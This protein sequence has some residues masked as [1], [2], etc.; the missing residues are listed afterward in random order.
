MNKKYKLYSWIAVAVALTVF[1][2]A[3]IFMS[4]LSK[5]TNIKI[6]LTANKKYD[7]TDASYEFL[8]GY[9]KD[10]KL[11]IL[12]S[13]TDQD[14]NARAILD[15]YAAANSHIKIENVDVE[16]NPSFGKE[17]ANG[18]VL[19]SNSVIVASG[20]KSRVIEN[21]E[22]YPVENGNITGIDVESKITSALKF[23]SSEE[24][25]VVCF[26]VGHDEADFRGAREAL[27]AEN[28]DVR[29]I[30]TMTEDIPAET[31]VL[32]IPR[33]MTDFSTE[34]IA[35]LDSYV[36]S[37][38]AVQLYVSGECPELP[39]LNGWLNTSGIG[40]NENEI[41]ESQN[42]VISVSGSYVF[43]ANYVKNAVTEGII[44]K[45]MIS[46]YIPFAKSLK[47]TS[48]SGAYTVEEYLSSSE[49]SYTSTNFKQPTRDTADYEGESDIA[50]MSTNADTN[51]RIY[52]SG[53]TMMLSFG[54]SEI[55]SMGFANIEYF[56]ALTNSMSGAGEAFVIPVKSVGADMLIMNSIQKGVM[57]VIVI[58][59]VPLAFLASGIIIFFRRRNM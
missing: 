28:Y 13:V 32:I 15:R 58:I 45:K 50:L 59:L 53:T 22:F 19:T 49:N 56:T 23:V 4:T 30:A 33:P 43:I 17:Y 20:D 2:L 18:R 52:V 41:V 51:G 24:N 34:E 48:A 36:R 3:N 37:G 12:A 54:V 40:V 9:D 25:P 29:D 1:V 26:T 16:K 39:A 31:E 44:S 42:N 47:K 38:G 5:K 46:G 35:R 10:T 21:S 55:N 7:L 6:D 14:T 11:Y 57:M 27:E 8:K